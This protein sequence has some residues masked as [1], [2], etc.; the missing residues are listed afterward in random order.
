MI[1]SQTN[2]TTAVIFLAAVLV[3]MT[4]TPATAQT[5]IP[6]RYSTRAQGMGGAMLLSAGPIEAGYFNPGALTQSKGL[7]VYLGAQLG[8]NNDAINFVNFLS[9]NSQM[10]DPVHFAG[11]P[12]A[13]QTSFLNDL[14]GYTD[15]WYQLKVD[16]LVGVQI[17]SLCLSGYSV[18]RLGL[19][20]M[21]PVL[22][23]TPL[24]PQVRVAAAADMVVNAGLGLQLGRMFHGG[25]GVRF[26][27]RQRSAIQILEPEDVDDPIQ[28]L[29]GF[30]T[31]DNWLDDPPTALQVDVGGMVTLGKAFA[32]GGVVR[33]LVS[34]ADEELARDWEPEIAAGVRLKPMELLLGIPLVIIRDI[35]LE[36]DLRDVLNVRGEQ[37]LEKLHLGAEV[38]L[39]LIALR[40]GYFNGNLSLGAG[41]HLLIVDLSAAVSHVEQWTPAGVEQQRLFS[42]AAAIGF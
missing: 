1:R 8:T 22:T 41:I 4:A 17:G 24:P 16:P 19:R 11:Q 33:G 25:V 13:T 35:T 40:A 12:L 2:R 10:L 30:A 38:K 3:V 5:P 34:T 29:N 28:F 27:Q 37:Y 36:A 20:A 9:D 18:S 32:A 26:M 6:M 31:K 23:P 15:R 14:N 7:H 42:L 21:P 39:P